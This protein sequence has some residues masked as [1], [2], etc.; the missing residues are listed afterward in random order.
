LVLLNA[1]DTAVED[2]Q[3]VAQQQHQQSDKPLSLT[4]AAVTAHAKA[5]SAADANAD[6]IAYA[7]PEKLQA[8]VPAALRETRKSTDQALMSPKHHHHQI[9]LPD[10]PNIKPLM[11][12]SLNRPYTGVCFGSRVQH[13]AAE[14]G[15]HSDGPCRQL[16]VTSAA[17]AV[18][19]VH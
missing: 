18:T 17:A 7:A 6:F 9:M 19:E 5:I 14:L 1:A 15:T 10:M 13:A 12:M 8:V 11:A 16:L 4:A 3:A 2:E